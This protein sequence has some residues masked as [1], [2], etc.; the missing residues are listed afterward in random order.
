MESFG[1]EEAS[2]RNG[3]ALQTL[4][5]DHGIPECLH[6]GVS[7]GEPWFGGIFHVECTLEEG[8]GVLRERVE[9]C[10]L[11]PPT[12]IGWQPHPHP[13]PGHTHTVLLIL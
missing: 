7:P 2:G 5:W 12:E 1:L 3:R 11:L 4:A 9:A 6:W 10:D 13:H 8:H